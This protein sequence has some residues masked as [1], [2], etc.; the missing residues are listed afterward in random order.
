LFSAFSVDDN[1]QPILETPQLCFHLG[2]VTD[3]IFS[4]RLGRS[5]PHTAQDHRRQ[6]YAALLLHGSPPSVSET[7]LDHMLEPMPILGYRPVADQ[8]NS[9]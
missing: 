9:A 2:L 1:F 5:A 3:W 8:K 6:G 7:L 4:G